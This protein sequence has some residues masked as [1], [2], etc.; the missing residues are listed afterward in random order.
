ML[1]ATGSTMTAAIS[2]PCCV[3]ERAD[4]AEIV[5]G[6]DERVG[7]EGAGTPGLSGR[8]SVATPEPAFTSRPSAWPW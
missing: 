7:G 2:S 6:R 1:P 4:G 8:P 3:E 5:V